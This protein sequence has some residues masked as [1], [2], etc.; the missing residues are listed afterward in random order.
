MSSATEVRHLREQVGDLIARHDR[1]RDVAEFSRYADDPVGFIRD[2]LGSDP[3]QAQEQIAEAVRDGPRVV[4]RSA[5]GCGKGWLAARL[6]L[7][8]CYARRGLAIVTAPTLRQARDV[9]MREIRAAFSLCPDLPGE[10]FEQSLRI[11]E[12]RQSGIL[13]FTSNEASRWQGL[14]HPSLLIV[15]DEGQGC[16]SDVYEAAVACVP[17]RTLVLG[18]PV[19]FQNSAERELVSL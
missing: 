16:E 5:N 3:W 4:V 12:A 8:W 7:W 18:N 2:V 15:I 6:L 10:L 11:D 9:M 13:A 17:E 14:H 19:L 1:A